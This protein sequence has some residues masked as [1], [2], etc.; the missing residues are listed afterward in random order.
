MMKPSTGFHSRGGC[1]DK[2]LFLFM[3]FNNF[4]N[5]KHFLTQCSSTLFSSYC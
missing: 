4:S 5:I 2:L 1:T 3:R